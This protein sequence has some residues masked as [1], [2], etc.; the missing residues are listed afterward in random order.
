MS[1]QSVVLGFIT[2]WVNPTSQPQPASETLAPVDGEQLLTQLSSSMTTEYHNWEDWP[3][4]ND[5]TKAQLESIASGIYDDMQGWAEVRNED[6]TF[7]GERI[8]VK[9]T[10]PRGFEFASEKV[11]DG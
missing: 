5:E 10:M 11:V 9:G 2:A 4:L 1:G 3:G 6:G 7:T 8:L